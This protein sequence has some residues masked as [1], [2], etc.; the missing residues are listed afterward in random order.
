MAAKE[1]VGTITLSCCLELSSYKSVELCKVPTRVKVH[2][3]PSEKQ[4]QQM[5][6]KELCKESGF[7]T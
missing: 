2:M 7:P 4:L 5:Y 3:I 1:E 6:G